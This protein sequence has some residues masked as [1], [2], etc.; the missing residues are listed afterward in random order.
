MS[1]MPEWKAQYPGVEEMKLAVMGCIVNG[2]GREQACPTSVS[3]CRERL[4]TRSAPVYVDGK[5]AT[6]L[7]G[8]TGLWKSS[9]SSWMSMC[10]GRMAARKR[11]RGYGKPKLPVGGPVNANTVHADAVAKDDGS[12]LK[13]GVEPPVFAV[14][15]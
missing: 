10:N 8:R 4:K 7:R 12:K 13:A 11:P 5:L 6:T 3:R 1:A 14:I 15:Q 9:R 2:P